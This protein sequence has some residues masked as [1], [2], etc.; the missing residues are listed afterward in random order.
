[1][2]F[3]A[4]EGKSSNVNRTD[5]WDGVYYADGACSD[6]DRLQL[7]VMNSFMYKKITNTVSK[8]AVKKGYLDTCH[9][10]QWPTLETSKYVLLTAL[11]S[12][13]VAP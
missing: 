4:A 3:Q 7:M 13:M 12:T 5:E 10:T 2:Q 11:H 6:G 8:T 1:M 9:S